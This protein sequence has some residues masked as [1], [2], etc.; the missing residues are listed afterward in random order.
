MVLT[1]EL[2]RFFWAGGTGYE[3]ELEVGIV[4][5]LDYH[6]LIYGEQL[7]IYE[8]FFSLSSRKK[9]RD[10]WIVMRISH[11]ADAQYCRAG[12]N[13]MVLANKNKCG[14]Q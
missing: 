1:R 12:M 9:R 4:G 7:T 2:S 14:E 8:F 13:N 11:E 6:K 3:I 5:R 10:N